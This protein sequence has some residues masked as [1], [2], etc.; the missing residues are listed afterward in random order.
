MGGN[1]KAIGAGAPSST[2]AA[3]GRRR[4]VFMDVT[5][6]CACTQNAAAQ[7]AACACCQGAPASPGSAPL[8]P[9]AASHYT[10]TQIPPPQSVLQRRGHPSLPARLL[11]GVCAMMLWSPTAAEE[12]R[13][14]AAHIR[15]AA[16]RGTRRS[17]QP[18]HKRCA[19]KHARQQHAQAGHTP[20]PTLPHPA[21]T[22][23]GH[24]HPAQEGG[25]PWA[26]G[27]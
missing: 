24:P 21:C 26:R 4:Q 12:G 22:T 23:P 7:G 14:G 8:P 11:A 2:Q 25:G 9:Y 6:V 20:D 18:H 16:A 19:S 1:N 3:T 10:H 5:A 13:P 15:R 27:A 17:T